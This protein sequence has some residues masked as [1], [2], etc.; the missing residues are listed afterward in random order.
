[1][2]ICTR[3]GADAQL[4]YH[5]VLICLRCSDALEHEIQQANL[6]ALR[7]QLA[8]GAEPIPDDLSALAPVLVMGVGKA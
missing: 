8:M 7:S 1:M 6:H 4:Y 2:E 3:C 5:N